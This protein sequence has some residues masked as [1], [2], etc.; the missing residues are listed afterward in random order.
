MLTQAARCFWT[1][2]RAILRASGREEQVTR[3]RRNWVGLGMGGLYRIF[4]RRIEQQGAPYRT[5]ADKEKRNLSDSV[6]SAIGLPVKRPSL[7][8]LCPPPL[9]LSIHNNS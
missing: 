8:P 7:W 4:D 2:A 3:T 6:L 1:M 5:R 9:T